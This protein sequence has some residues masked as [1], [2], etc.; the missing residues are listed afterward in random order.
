MVA[1]ETTMVSNKEATVA[2][3][4]RAMENNMAAMPDMEATTEATITLDGDLKVF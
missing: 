4:D 2:T 3:V 1:T